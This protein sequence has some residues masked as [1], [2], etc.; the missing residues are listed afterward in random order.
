MKNAEKQKKNDFLTRT[1][2]TGVFTNSVFFIFVSLQI[3]HFAK[4][5]IKIGVSPPPP[6]K[7]KNKT[8]QKT[9]I[10]VKNWSK[11]NLKIGPSMLRNIIG[12]VLTYKI[13]FFGCVLLVFENHLLSAGRMRCYKKN[14]KNKTIKMDHF[15]T[16]KRQKLDQLLSLQY[17]Y[18]CGLRPPGFR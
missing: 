4:N 13:V 3:L 16:Y 18:I 9:K 2:S 15:L 1:V 6:P 14:K 12:P 17:I 8:K 5:T 11:Y 7:K 10:Y